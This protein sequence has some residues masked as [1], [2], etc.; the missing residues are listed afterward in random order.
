LL[1]GREK[2]KESFHLAGRPW[3]GG[4]LRR[5]QRKLSASFS[6]RGEGRG[7]RTP[8]SLL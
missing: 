8:G 5:K 3:R 4:T 6:K 7:G 1:E 2:K